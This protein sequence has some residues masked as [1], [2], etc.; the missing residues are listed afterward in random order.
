MTKKTQLSKAIAL[1]LSGAAL[2]VGALTDASAASTTMYN[3]ST[4][5][6]VSTYNNALDQAVAMNSINPIGAPVDGNGSTWGYWNLNRGSYGTDGWMNGGLGAATE[7]VGI[8]GSSAV[9]NTAAFGYTGKHLNWGAEFTGA[10][11]T[12]TIST[13]DAF[14]RYGVYADIDVAKGAWS[15]NAVGGAGGWRHDLDH[16]LFKTD[17]AGLVTLSAVGLVQNGTAFGF[18]IFKGT[19]GTGAYNHHGAWNQGNNASGLS[20]NSL[21]AGG[22]NFTIAD[23]VAYSVGGASP[24]NLNTISFNA[25]AGQIYSIYLGGYR[26]GAWGVTTDGYALT[27]SQAAPVPLPGAIWLFGGALASLIGANRRKR[28]MPA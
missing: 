19:G 5:A 6:G 3:M 7:W 25:D 13:S 23:V 1:A 22:T 9:S 26:N 27:I 11:N 18:T 8:N 28:V 14:N 12:A 4:G 15:D 10:G 21:P 24:T 16:G 20:G 17:T 2:S